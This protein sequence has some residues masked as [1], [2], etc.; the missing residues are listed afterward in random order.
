VSGGERQR[1]AV[2]RV[3]LADRPVVILDEPTAHLDVPTATALA[4]EIEE[5]TRGR[6]A[7]VVTHRPAE[8]PDLPSTAVGPGA[9]PRAPSPAD[10]VAG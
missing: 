2:A 3:L 1:L 6:T 8:F 7:L 4:A 5:V 9:R 10:A